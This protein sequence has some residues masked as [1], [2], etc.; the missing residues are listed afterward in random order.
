MAFVIQP[1]PAAHAGPARVIESVLY[2]YKATCSSFLRQTPTAQAPNP[3]KPLSCNK[4]RGNFF[5]EFHSRYT[6][7]LVVS[8]M[9]HNG[10]SSCSYALATKFFPSEG[11]DWPEKPG[12][13]II[14][15]LAP[16][17]A[18]H[19]YYN[20][21]EKLQFRGSHFDRYT[22]NLVA[23]KV[24]P[25]YRLE[26]KGCE[27]A[28]TDQSTYPL[29]CESVDGFGSGTMS[30]VLHSRPTGR[31]K[32]FFE[33]R[34]LA[35]KPHDNAFDKTQTLAG[36]LISSAEETGDVIL[37]TQVSLHQWLLKSGFKWGQAFDVGATV[38][39]LSPCAL[40]CILALNE[41]TRQEACVVV[42]IEFAFL[43]AFAT[44]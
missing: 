35:V 30:A 21:P 23:S 6:H 8:E 32:I 15:S 18:N 28:S 31:I 44:W 11:C 19:G 26:M 40:R 42:K 9:V 38:N 2:P 27:V 7:Q 34:L 22:L 29:F 20:Q 12:V 37:R 17:P 41:C 13:V 25:G 39:G 4:G 33:L 1:V 3:D 16:T 14:A 10:A 24:P 36:R 5:L 43:I